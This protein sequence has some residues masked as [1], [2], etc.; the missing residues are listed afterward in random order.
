VGTFL[1]EV[2]LQGERI[3]AFVTEERKIAKVGGKQKFLKFV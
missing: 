1:N 2:T 3:K